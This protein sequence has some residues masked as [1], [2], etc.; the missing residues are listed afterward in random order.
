MT[1]LIGFHLARR[2]ALIVAPAATLALVCGCGSVQNNLVSVQNKLG[3][4]PT[5]V[6]V[7]PL[8][9]QRYLASAKTDAP[10]Y[11]SFSD[12]DDAPASMA[13]K[14]VLASHNEFDTSA[15]SRRASFNLLQRIDELRSLEQQGHYEE[16]L[17]GLES[18]V[19]DGIDNNTVYHRLAILYDVTQQPHKAD[20]MF[21]RALRNAP[22]DVE[23]LCDFG[24]HQEIKGDFDSAIQV[25]RDALL[26]SPKHKRLNNHMAV[27]FAKTNRAKEARQHFS[28]AGL[29]E[30]QIRQNLK[31]LLPEKK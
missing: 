6:L 2:L 3:S 28:A 20:L 10:V 25:Y 18:L 9:M 14:V 16:A 4:L 21:A 29:S 1:L 5:G 31:L 7:Q 12:L 30:T 11:L 22:G 24:F 17:Q 26:R 23:L 13:G 19:I 8:E 15:S 27:A